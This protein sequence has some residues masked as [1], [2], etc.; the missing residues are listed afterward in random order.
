MAGVYSQL[1][2]DRNYSCQDYLTKDLHDVQ[3]KIEKSIRL[4]PPQG[5]LCRVFFPHSN[6]RMLRHAGE[7]DTHHWP[8]AAARRN[9]SANGN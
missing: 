2:P 6:P 3:A 8:L 4:M 7:E 9:L 1:I 5:Q